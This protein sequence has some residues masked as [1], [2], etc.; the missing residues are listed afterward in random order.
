MSDVA[1]F[2]VGFVLFVMTSTATL[3]FGYLQFRRIYRADQAAS[4]GPEIVMQGSTEVFV[5]PDRFPDRTPG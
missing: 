4:G 3:L 1:L 2:A 5:T